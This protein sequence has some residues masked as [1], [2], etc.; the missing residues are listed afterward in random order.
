MAYTRKSA[1]ERIAVIDKKIDSLNQ[2]ITADQIKIAEL[3]KKKDD[4]LNPQ[5]RKRKVTATAIINKA[6]EAGMTD[7]EIAA[8]LGIEL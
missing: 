1:E 8:K 2:R 3:T 6:K 4:I 5:P 7:A